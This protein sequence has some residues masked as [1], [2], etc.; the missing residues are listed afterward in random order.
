MK[1]IVDER[2]HFLGGKASRIT[3]LSFVILAF[4]TMFIDCCVINIP[5]TAH[6]TILSIH[7]F[8]GVCFFIGLH[9][10][11]QV[12]FKKK[13]REMMKDDWKTGMVHVQDSGM[14]PSPA[15]KGRLD[16]HACLRD[17]CRRSG[18]APN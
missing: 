2:A 13:L 1:E 3:F 15:H 16:L 7:E 11:I 9:Y 17:S 8:Y 12:A 18:Y 6:N 10:L 14:G 4:L 5:L